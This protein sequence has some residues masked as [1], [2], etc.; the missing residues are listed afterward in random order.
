M[1]DIKLKFDAAKKMFFDRQTV[2]RAVDQATAKVFSKFGAY[3]RQRAKTSIRKR[4]AASAPGQPPSSHTGRLK[5][6]I[7]FGYDR[8]KKSVVIGPV[9]LNKGGRGSPE[10]TTVL[11]AL[12]YG[13][14]SVVSTRHK[15]SRN[16]K[17]NTQRTIHIQARPF[18]QP[19]FENEKSKLPA[20]WANSI[21][22]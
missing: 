11:P 10:G 19:A 9:L 12:E 20:L 14:L 8:P 16:K 6:F 2:L 21:K 4:K 18:M 3:V 7:F 5:S 15:R 1:I 13:G 17:Y 22:K